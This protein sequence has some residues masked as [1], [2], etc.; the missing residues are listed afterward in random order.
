MPTVSLSS[1]TFGRPGN[2]PLVLLHGWGN[3]AG[4]WQFLI[5]LLQEQYCIQAVD[6]PGYG[7]S[8]SVEGL[9]Q[10]RELVEA[11]VKNS[12]GNA[13]WC[14]WSL[15]GMLATAVAD[16]LCKQS[17]PGIRG[18][19]TLCTNPKFIHDDTWTHAMS[20]TAFRAFETGLKLFP[21]TT[22]KQFQGLM[23]KG[24]IDAKADLRSLKEISRQADV[25]GMTTLV[26]SLE[27]LKA[28]D[29]RSAITGLTIP[30][31]HLFGAHDALVPARVSQDLQ[32]LNPTAVVQVLPD[33]GHVPQISHASLLAEQIHRFL[34]LQ[35]IREQSIASTSNC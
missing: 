5:P 8:Q 1:Q 28:L 24:G 2:M 4:I 20:G 11:L 21:E 13:I 33:A 10:Q 22:I 19:I 17:R 25:P 32:S 15:G 30:Q 27:L 29:V 16:R 7:R 14:G 31:L 34:K 6:L 12:P 26:E 9:W 23:V 18:L 35:V 3:H